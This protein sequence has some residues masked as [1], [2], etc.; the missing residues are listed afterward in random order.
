LYVFDPATGRSHSTSYAP[1]PPSVQNNPAWTPDNT[2]LVLVVRTGNLAQVYVVDAFTATSI[3]SGTVPCGGQAINP[4]SWVFYDGTSLDLA[5]S[6]G[7]PVEVATCFGGSQHRVHTATGSTFALAGVDGV[8]SSAGNL[9]VGGADQLASR[10]EDVFIWSGDS[11]HRL[12]LPGIS[13]P[14][15]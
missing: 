15:W 5:F 13:Q 9:I 4:D 12:Q 3:Q 8:G 6:D 11:V 10:G 1:Q 2:H 7:G 14:T